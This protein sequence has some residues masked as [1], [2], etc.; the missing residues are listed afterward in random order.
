VSSGKGG[1]VRELQRAGGELSRGLLGGGGRPEGGASRQ[2]QV[3]VA[4]AAG[5]GARGRVGIAQGGFNRLAGE[6]EGV[7]RLGGG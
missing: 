2:A 3:V 5:G 7:G 1:W 4:M 6:E